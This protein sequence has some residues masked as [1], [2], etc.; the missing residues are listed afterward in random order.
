MF[1]FQALQFQ[2]S[3]DDVEQCV[4]SVEKEVSSE[5][6]GSD[7]QSVNRLL[8]KLQVLEDEV[9]GLRDRIQVQKLS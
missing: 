9:D 8:K 7:L 5:D 6:T 3:L 4:L 2:R 1:V